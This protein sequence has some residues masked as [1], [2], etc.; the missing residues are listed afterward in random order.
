MNHLFFSSILAL[1]L[2]TSPLPTET[3][4]QRILEGAKASQTV[5]FGENHYSPYD[6]NYV[7]KLLPELKKLGYTYFAVELDGKYKDAPNY[8][9]DVLESNKPNKPLS[10]LVKTAESVGMGIVFYDYSREIKGYSSIK[11]KLIMSRREQK[12][13]ANLQEMIFDKDPK[14]KVVVFCGISHIAEKEYGLVANPEICKIYWLGF[15]L[16]KYTCG[17]NLSVNLSSWYTPYADIDASKKEHFN[18]IRNAK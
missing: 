13:F 16:E 9:K 15:F 5:I 10:Q 2:N 8:Y 7:A 1:T 11:N 17:K 18:E 3:L 14:A 4:E 12:A 6:D